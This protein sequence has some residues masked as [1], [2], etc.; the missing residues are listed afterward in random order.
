MKAGVAGVFALSL[1][2]ACASKNAEMRANL[3]TFNSERTPDKLIARGKAF[4]ALGDT[5]RAEE[6]YAAALEAG[7]NEKEIMTLLLEV[8]VRDGRYRAAI[9]YARPYIQ[10][11]PDDVRCRYVLGTLYQA[12]AEPKN[13]RTELE[14]VVSTMP[15]EADPHFA[16]ATILRDEDKDLVAAEGQF[17]EYL[18]LAP[19]GNHAEEARASLLQ[20]VQ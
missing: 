2:V 16:L 17:R 18:R 13:A 5:T 6:Y 8:C 9:E 20:V 12:V 14:V 15:N 4:S 3:A 10:K 19:N 11:H 1:L 7:G